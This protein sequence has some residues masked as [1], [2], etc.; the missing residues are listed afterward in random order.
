MPAP[1]AV[2]VADVRTLNMDDTTLVWRDGDEE[3]GCG[4]ADVRWSRVKRFNGGAVSQ[5]I[6]NDVAARAK[7]VT[8]FAT[9]TFPDRDRRTCGISDDVSDDTAQ[10]DMLDRVRIGSD[11]E[12]SDTD[13]RGVT[14]G[15]YV[16]L[17]V[18]VAGE[19]TVIFGEP[20]KAPRSADGGG[21]VDAAAARSPFETWHL[22][23]SRPIWRGSRL[24]G[25]KAQQSVRLSDLVTVQEICKPS[26]SF[27]MPGLTFL[28][29][30]SLLKRNGELPS[31]RFGCHKALPAECSSVA[32]RCDQ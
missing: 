32:C 2:V 11:G 4:R 5:R 20:V 12:R 23:I 21:G 15:D 27:G 10:I 7:V 19:D 25:H 30:E 13:V 8:V 6:I 1:H 24:P 29:Q 22:H 16:A 31:D 9:S 28:R 17:T 18:S 3:F 14:D 26:R